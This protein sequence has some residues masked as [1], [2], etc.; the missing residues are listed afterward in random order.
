[1]C[2][3]AKPNISLLKELKSCSGSWFYKHLVPLGPKTRAPK[4]SL[5]CCEN[6]RG[7]RLGLFLCDGPLHHFLNLIQVE[8]LGHIGERAHVYQ[9]LGV[10]F[11]ALA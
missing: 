7:W 9:S 10:L 11:A 6:F 8:R 4:N 2:I 3:S 5:V 1:M